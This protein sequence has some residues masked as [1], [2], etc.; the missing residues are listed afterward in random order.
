MNIQQLRYLRAVI[1]TGTFSGAA[2]DEGVSVQAVSKSLSALEEEL[3]QPVFI[4]RS[5]GA[6]PTAFG[7]AL[8]HHAEKVLQAF[9]ETEQFASS[10]AIPPAEHEGLAI[11]LA[12]PFFNNYRIVCAGL[13]RFLKR[14]LK[15]PVS[16]GLCAGYEAIPRLMDGSLDVL[17]TIGE[18]ESPLCGSVPLGTLPTGAFVSKGHP[19][20]GRESVTL[21]D[22]APYPVGYAAGTD[23]FN[24]T[25]V[26]LYKKNG[27]A[28]SRVPIRTSEDMKR[29]TKGNGY[30]LAVGIPAFAPS[31]S[32]K[33]LRIAPE[34]HLP[35]SVCAVTSRTHK[36]DC[37]LVFE[38][39][40]RDKFS[41]V[42]DAIGG[43]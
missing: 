16:L 6:V 17:I 26:N 35:V 43:K 11:L 22:L 41:G 18:Y 24:E 14:Q 37:Y 2:R 28:S 9:E 36:S 7:I 12:V 15:M 39:F 34:D 40:M 1:R 42:F 32:W 33:M 19:L 38:R 30:S 10:H 23:D 21:E 3:G 27:L 31:S 5:K 25:I 13:E 29:H 20:Y 4:R 8:E